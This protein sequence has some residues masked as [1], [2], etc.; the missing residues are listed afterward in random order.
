MDVNGER[1]WQ[2]ITYRYTASC[3]DQIHGRINNCA[4]ECNLGFIF[5]MWFF[6][7]MKYQQTIL[8]NTLLVSQNIDRKSVFSF[9]FLVWTCFWF[10][11]LRVIVCMNLRS[12][13]LNVLYILSTTTKHHGING[14]TRVQSSIIQR[15]EKNNDKSI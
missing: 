10:L 2:N 5:S 12:F 7:L 6:L 1:D 11:F 4:S 13:T 8:L 9:H 15:L 14:N 3:C